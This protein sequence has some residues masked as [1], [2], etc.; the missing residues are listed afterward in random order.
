MNFL[1]LDE[2]LEFLT[3]PGKMKRVMLNTYLRNTL[4]RGSGVLPQCART[5]LN[6]RRGTRR[7]PSIPRWT[8]VRMPRRHTPV[9]TI[10]HGG[11]RMRGRHGETQGDVAELEVPSVLVGEVG[12]QEIDERQGRLT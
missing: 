6:R 3:K 12:T 2:F 8:A 5:R 7:G 11:V 1:S 4:S 9:V 10:P